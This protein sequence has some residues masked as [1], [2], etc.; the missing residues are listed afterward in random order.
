LGAL[1]EGAVLDI[2]ISILLLLVR[3]GLNLN[4]CGTFLI[5][6]IK[7]ANLGKTNRVGVGCLN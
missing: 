5:I 3:V 2:D 1:R 6:S 4:N 7:S